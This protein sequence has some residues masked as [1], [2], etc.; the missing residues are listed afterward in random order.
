MRRTLLPHL[1]KVLE[2]DPSGI[3][4]K[5]SPPLSNTQRP[6]SPYALCSMGSVQ[7]KSNFPVHGLPFSMAPSETSLGQR[8]FQPVLFWGI[9]TGDAILFIQSLIYSNVSNKHI[10]HYQNAAT[11]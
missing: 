8:E 6:R 4:P 11:Q 9:L 7:S 10:P 5:C 1:H 3:G 2:R